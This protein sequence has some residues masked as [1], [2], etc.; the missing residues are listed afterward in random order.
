MATYVMSATQIL[1]TSVATKFNRRRSY[2]TADL[3]PS[4]VV[5]LLWTHMQ[6]RSPAWRMSLSTRLR[7]QRISSV[8]KAR[9]TLG[10]P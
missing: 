9:C 3:L 7:S 1:S 5:A 4:R 2:A 6:P 8:L 10:D